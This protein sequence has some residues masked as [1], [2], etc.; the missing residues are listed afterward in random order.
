VI[1]PIPTTTPE[2]HHL[3]AEGAN[4]LALVERNGMRIDVDYLDRKIDETTE[5]V[6]RTEA[7]LREMDEFKLQRRQFGAKTN[8]TSRQQLA[9][10]LYDVQG[11]ECHS[12]TS[13]GK[14]GKKQKQLDET[15]LE[16]IDSKYCKGFLRLEKLRK[17]L[18]TYLKGLRSE[19]VDGFIH[20]FYHLSTVRSYRGS[21]SDPNAQ[22]LP[23]RDGEA[24]RL[25]REAFIPRDGHVLIETDYST[26]EVR[27]ACCLSGDDKLTYDTVHGDMHRDMA[28]ECFKLDLDDVTK[29]TRQSAKGGFVF[30]QFY[31]DWYKACA[32]N[33]WDAVER[34]GLETVAGVP[35]FDH[36]ASRGITS[37][38]PADAR[39]EPTPGSLQHHIKKVEKRFWN[40]R[41]STYNKFRQ[42]LVSDY[43]EV[44]WFPL[45]TGF[46]CHGV[47]SKNQVINYP[48]QGPA[49]HCLLWSLIQINKWLRKNKMRTKIIGQIHDSIIADVHKNEADDYIEKVREV[50]T[51]GL[52]RAWPWVVVPM[53]VDMERGDLNWYGMK[54]IAV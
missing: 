25:V 48:V 15:A 37:L 8:L 39:T 28:A 10:I 36:L 41:F 31:G 24:A 51:T 45:A 27:V 47:F 11:H 3:F 30:A 50:T 54:E 26:L 38:G 12:Y 44:G 35:M 20:P 46:I 16:R 4:E 1:S 33:L 32:K 7:R 22:N 52:Q 17:S 29:A 2:A 9:D 42:Q 23:K 43:R 40:E 49:F 5:R 19:V 14:S 53:S 13:G 18:A 21:S 6:K 34:S